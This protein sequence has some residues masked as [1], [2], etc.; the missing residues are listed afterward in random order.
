MGVLRLRHGGNLRSDGE[1]SRLGYG[2]PQAV[3]IVDVKI[4]PTMSIVQDPR[5]GLI[6][7]FLQVENSLQRE[8]RECS[9]C[10]YSGVRI[11]M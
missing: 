5:F 2:F 1:K 6:E 8:R 3:P 10:S 4:V 7:R 11:S 9:L